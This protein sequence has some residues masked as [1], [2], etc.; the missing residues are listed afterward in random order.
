MIRPENSFLCDGLDCDITKCSL[1][2]RALETHKMSLQETWLILSEQS[3][4]EVSVTSVFK[5]G[6]GKHLAERKD[7]K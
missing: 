3:Y 1:A 6:T 5:F 2:K 7:S 4:A